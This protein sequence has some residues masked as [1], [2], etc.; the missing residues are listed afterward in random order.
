M[1]LP[2]ADSD[3]EEQGDEIGEATFSHDAIKHCKEWICCQP[4]QTTKLIAI[5][6]MDVF[7]MRFRLTDVSAA[8][9]S[10]LMVGFNEKTIRICR[11]EFYQC[12]GD[13]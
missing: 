7:R 3:T 1:V 11:I 5:L 4:T 12:H 10:S 8:K 2:R 9:E 6:M 13:L